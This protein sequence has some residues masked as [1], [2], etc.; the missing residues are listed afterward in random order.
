MIS[1][2]A[3]GV[4]INTLGTFATTNNLI[5]G[6]LIGADRSG[7]KSLNS[8]GQ[9]IIL[10]GT[11][12]NRIGTDGNGVGDVIDTLTGRLDQKRNSLT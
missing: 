3:I 6:N 7:T 4:I 1:G 8:G 9:G 11:N 2:N 10:Q 12:S 5:A